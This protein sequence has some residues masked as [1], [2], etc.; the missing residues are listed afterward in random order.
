MG[1]RKARE[2]KESSLETGTFFL[3]S[4]EEASPPDV[5]CTLAAGRELLDERTVCSRPPALGQ[6]ASGPYCGGGRAGRGLQSPFHKGDFTRDV[7]GRFEFL[8]G[9]M[10][11]VP[12]QLGRYLSDGSVWRWGRSDSLPTVSAEAETEEKPAEWQNL[13]WFAVSSFLTELFG[14]SP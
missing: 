3:P 1:P 5:P 2:R 8:L 12:L 7:F 4:S 6:T 10:E 14:G 9:V 11:T 13:G